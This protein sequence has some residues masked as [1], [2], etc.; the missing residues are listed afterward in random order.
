VALYRSPTHTTATLVDFVQWGTGG[1]LKDSTRDVVAAAAGQWVHGTLVAAPVAGMSVGRNRNAADTNSRADWTSTGGKDSS[2]ATPGALNVAI[3]GTDITPPAPVADF[4]ATPVLGREGLVDLSWANPPNGDLAGVRVVRSY[5]TYPSHFNDENPVYAGM[6]GHFEDTS[7]PPGQV[8]FYTAFAYDDSGNVSCPVNSSQGRAVIPQREYVVY[9]DLKGTGWVDW[10][11]NDLVVTED[12]AVQL[13]QDGI[14]Q[15]NILFKAAARGSF[16][17]HV[18][19]L[20]MQVNGGF[21]AAISRYDA[22]GDLITSTTNSAFDTVNLLIFDSTV[23]ALPGNYP[24]GTSNARRGSGTRAGYSTA[25]TITLASPALN[26]PQNADLPPFDP[27][28]HVVNTGQDIHLMQSGNIGNSQT[29]WNAMSPLKGRD[30]PLGL[31]FNQAWAWPAESIPIWETYPQYGPYMLSGG[32]ASRDWFT[33]PDLSKIWRPVAA[34]AGPQQSEHQQP[35]TQPAQTAPNT[36]RCA[37][38]SAACSAGWPRLMPAQIFASP[39]IVDV[40]GDGNNEV[41]VASQDGTVNVTD[42]AGVALPGWPIYTWTVLRG[43]PAV[44]DIDGDGWPEIVAGG[45]DQLLR[46]WHADGSTVGGFPVRLDGSLRSSPALADLDDQPGAEIVIATGKLKVY[47]V[48]GQGQFV[49]HW[50]VQMNGVA[51]SYG[52]LILVSTPAVGDLDGDDVPEIVAGSTDGRVYAWRLDGTRFTQLWPHATGDWIYASPLIVDLDGDGYRDVV[53][54][55]GDG[56]LYAWRG[57]GMPLAGFPVKVRGGMI[58]SPA[59]ADLDGDG[60]LEV[61]FAT[62][63]GK[64]Y[65][66]RGNGS[67]VKGWPRDARSPIYSSPVVADVDGDA[68][69]EVIAGS[70]AGQVNAWHADGIPVVDWPRL[71]NDWV[72]ASPAAGDLDGDGLTEIVAG[73]FD[74]YVYAWDTA[75][76]PAAIPWPAFHGGATHAGLLDTGPVLAPPVPH[77]FYMPVIT[78]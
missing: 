9:E 21:T 46:A 47:A 57:N 33:V 13:N 65:A 60:R 15:I 27:W 66:V 54:A 10:D 75:G 69:P 35:Q 55:S 61:I 38:A 28:I 40:N 68:K 36:D 41:V 45:D 70:H 12:S 63:L 74:G 44:G 11:T 43:S 19:N 24:D 4:A 59:V 14:Q 34:A 77:N 5:D 49:Q 73:S 56:R 18:F 78:R 76:N 67:L 39:L 17:D 71:T 53:A 50:P 64:V 42:A 52:N 30:L 26:P 25:V 20:G 3:P 31:S 51:E 1:V 29:V 8:V 22:D 58:A 6:A 37:T 72:V 32:A 7:L 48:T 2:Y 16:Y 23:K 62:V